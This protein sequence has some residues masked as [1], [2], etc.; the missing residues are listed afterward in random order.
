MRKN[1]KQCVCFED[2]FL[3]FLCEAE[4][5]FKKNNVIIVK[6]KI[7]ENVQKYYWL[8]YFGIDYNLQKY[9]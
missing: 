9:F 5:L 7:K 6:N 1:R 8:H 4:N 3:S 2:L